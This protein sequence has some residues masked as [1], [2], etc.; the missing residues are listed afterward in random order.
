[1]AADTTLDIYIIQ[2]LLEKF[3]VKKA[4]P[5]QELYSNF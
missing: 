2:Q 3:R 5:P 1:M 4:I